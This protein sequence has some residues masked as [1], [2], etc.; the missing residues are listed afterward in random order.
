VAI[1]SAHRAAAVLVHGPNAAPEP[2]Q[3]DAAPREPA[4]P[5]Q[6]AGTRR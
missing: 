4:R 3:A 1:A 6:R 2:E 5:R